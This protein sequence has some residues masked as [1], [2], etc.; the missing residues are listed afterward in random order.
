MHHVCDVNFLSLL[1]FYFCGVFIICTQFIF[2]SVMF[3]LQLFLNHLY[4]AD[5]SAK[6]R[7][8]HTHLECDR[9]GQLSLVKDC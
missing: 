5:T 3:S 2:Y 4:V 7:L 9:L 6:R 1:S 8:F